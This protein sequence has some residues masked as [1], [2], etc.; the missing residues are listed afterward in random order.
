[1]I[2]FGPSTITWHTAD[3][4][5]CMVV[6]LLYSRSLYFASC[7][8][9]ESMIYSALPQLRGIQL[10]RCYGRS[11]LYSRSLYFAVYMSRLQSRMIIYSALPQ[12]RGIQL[13]RCYGCMLA[14]FPV[15]VFCLLSRPR[16]Y[17]LFGHSTITWHTADQILWLYACSIPGHCILPRVAENAPFK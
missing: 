15:I 14:L 16:V 1:M 13:I 3:Q 8:G 12:L 6:C 11:L 9:P 10:I 7:R 17:D 5:L 4:M 2:H